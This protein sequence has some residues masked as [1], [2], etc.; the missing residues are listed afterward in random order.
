MARRACAELTAIRQQA[1]I[2][3][4]QLGRHPGVDID[5]A[6]AVAALAQYIGP[7]G[8]VGHRV[9]DAPARQCTRY[10]SRVLPA[11]CSALGLKPLEWSQA[12]NLTGKPNPYNWE[13]VDKAL[14]EAGAIV[15]LLTPDDEARLAEHLWSERESALEKNSCF[16]QGRTYSLKANERSQLDTIFF[17]STTRP[18]HAKRSPTHCARPVVPLT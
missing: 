8:V 12:S 13:I 5:P 9:H 10:R 7:K 11:R 4:D 3:R 18:N 1:P 15:A 6:P 16:N 2:A 17:N 14:S